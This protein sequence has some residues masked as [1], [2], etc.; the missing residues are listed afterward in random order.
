MV[1]LKRSGAKKGSC[2]SKVSNCR[3][4]LSA[5]LFVSK[6]SKPEAKHLTEGKSFSSFINSLL[7]G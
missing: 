2:G 4:Q 1:S 3:N 7:I 6:K 5:S